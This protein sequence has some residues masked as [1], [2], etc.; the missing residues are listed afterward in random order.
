MPEQQAEMHNSKAGYIAIVG[1]PNAGKSTLINAILGEKL[2]IVTPKPQTTRK[3]V[4]G[5]YTD[6]ANQIVFI[7]TPGILQAKYEMQKFMMEYVGSALDTADAIIFIVDVKK[8]RSELDDHS[9]QF[10]KSA[11][12]TNKPIIAI[13][14]KVDLY[15]D[16]KTVLP[17]IQYYHNLNFFDEIV[18]LSA[19]KQT[20]IDDL[21]KT[22]T[23]YLPE[24]PFYF[25]PEDIST[26]S[27][28]FFVSELIREQL[29]LSYSEEI[30]YSTEVVISQ[31]REKAMGKWFISAD[32]LVER[33][34]QKIILIGKSGE[35][36]KHIGEKAR[37]SIEDHLQRSVYLE[38][39]VKVREN[40]RNNKNMLKNLGY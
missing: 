16:V 5:I 20:Y 31:F 2:S 26:L 30:P 8:Y 7:D 34:S 37:I 1:K 29:F 9:L 23:K 32:I 21:V 35:K 11:K 24:N 28:R 22:L 17:I 15:E 18:P 39:F 13:L 12:Q 33:K 27:E 36:I 4:L 25:D 14:N 38:L 40:W 6:E 19:L 3:Q 10:L